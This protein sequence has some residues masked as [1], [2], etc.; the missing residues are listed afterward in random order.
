MKNHSF[1]ALALLLSISSFS[2]QTRY[3]SDP[4]T[5]F[6]EAKE[7]FQKD[8]F[9]LA[10]PLFKELQHAIRETD[11]A[12][13]TITVQEI[14][15][16]TTVCALKQGEGRAEIEAQQYIENII[17]ASRSSAMPQSGMNRPISRISV[18]GRSPT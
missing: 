12:N 7:Y 6:K 15:Y 17:S 2:Q 9:S 4:E 5:T 3:Y 16:Y 13:S 11:K 14:N 10:Y 8:Q 18:T 1:L